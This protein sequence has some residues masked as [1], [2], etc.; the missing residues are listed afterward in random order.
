[1]HI[2]ESVFSFKASAEVEEKYTP[3]IINDPIPNKI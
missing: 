1:M 2:I 3:Q